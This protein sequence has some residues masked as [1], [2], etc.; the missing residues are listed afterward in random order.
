MRVFQRPRLLPVPLEQSEAVPGPVG[1]DREVVD[2]APICE[3]VPRAPHWRP[4]ASMRLAAPRPPR[5]ADSR[6][7]IAW[8]PAD[9][10]GP[11]SA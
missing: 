5:G 11:S 3:E 2:T 8:G 6:G 1:D 7:I 9:H 4:A 10:S